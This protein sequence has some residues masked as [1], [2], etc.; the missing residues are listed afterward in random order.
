M[1]LPSSG[2]FQ[3]DHLEGEKDHLCERKLSMQVDI[4]QMSGERVQV[5]H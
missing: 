3:I 5:G 1:E 2:A 4:V